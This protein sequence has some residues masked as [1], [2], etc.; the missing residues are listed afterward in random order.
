[1]DELISRLGKLDGPSTDL[2]DAIA[3]LEGYRGH[4]LPYTGYTASIDAAL[5]LV[6]KGWW[7]EIRLC[8]NADA[9]RGFYHCKLERDG[10]VAGFDLEPDDE[11]EIE[12]TNA[13]TAAIAICR[14][15][16]EAKRIS[17]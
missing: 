8:K 7:V 4:P 2:D 10:D 17:T 5:S 12:A 11:M 14:A 1:M 3:R 9:P 6:P 15:A 13:P 16:L